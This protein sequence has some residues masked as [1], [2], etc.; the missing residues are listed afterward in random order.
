[1]KKHLADKYPRI[2]QQFDRIDDEGFKKVGREPFDIWLREGFQSLNRSTEE[3]SSRQGT[4]LVLKQA[5][6][7]V[8]S[9]TWGEKQQLT[10]HWVKEIWDGATDQLHE[11][12][13][14]SSRLH[15][16]LTN[17]HDEID[18]RVLQ[19]ADV[20][21]ITTT[22][23]ARRIAT[24][25]RIRSKVVICEEA[26]EVLEAHTV[27]A[28]L[29][30]VEH[31]IQIGDHEQLR[32]QINNYN[33]SLE[34][35]QGTMYQLDRSQF[36]RLSAS[37]PGRPALPITQLYLQRRMRPEISTLIR[38]TIYPD[39][40]DH[41]S[42]KKLPDV[43][44]MRNNV[45]WLDHENLEEGR[46]ADMHQKSHSN[47]W[48]VD[49]THALVRHI[50][51]QGVYNSTDLAVL[52]PYSGQLNRLRRN[53]R[54]DFEI[55]LSDRDQETLSKEGFSLEDDLPEAGQTAENPEPGSK[56]LQR[57][58][59]SELLR[60]ATVDNFQGEEAK[61]II[62]SLVRSNTVKKVGFPRT[63]NRINVLISRA[64]H[65]MYLIGN[66]NTYSNQPMWA[67]IQ[68]MLQATG[69]LGKELALCCPRHTATAIQVSQPEQFQRLSPEGGCQ[70]PCERRLPSCG[71]KC[72]GICHSESMHNVFLCPQPCQRL[73]STCQHSCPKICGE[74]C[75]LCMVKVHGVHLPC[76]HLKDDVPC[77]MTREFQSIRC[78][79]PVLKVVPGCNHAFEVPCF[80]DVTAA[81]FRCPTACNEILE[82]GHLCPGSCGACK[83]TKATDQNV[84]KHASCTK[85]C[86]RRFATCNHC[87]TRPCHQ[88]KECGTCL[89]DCE[90]S[91]LAIKA[92]SR[93][94]RTLRCKS[95][96]VVARDYLRL[97]AGALS[98]LLTFYYEASED[99][100]LSLKPTISKETKYDE[101]PLPILAYDQSPTPHPKHIAKTDII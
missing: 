9:L 82:C 77:H 65:G 28:L 44:G 4:T 54:D 33:L 89:S 8:Y 84:T 3:K 42:T 47:L 90:V 45:F 23:L 22:G 61:I 53:L 37:E 62:V 35:S 11:L 100:S 92:L 69:S 87:C 74:E 70:L 97:S 80:R 60:V 67:Q 79:A 49:M 18:R 72:K 14:E 39:L 51:R 56:V 5:T 68:S 12:I 94:S 25:Q 73:F 66:A 13:E 59:M 83:P 6:Q 26:A 20:I 27:S 76:E 7:N 101:Y 41:D 40:K 31:F 98:V 36:E 43:V 19:T 85:V 21:G 91:A 96:R 81:T 58:R 29:P 46:P 32:P 55:V 57:K 88:G 86:G 99:N 63:R 71:H 17:I 75:G 2:Y 16:E 95:L 15:K 30:S 52:T 38:Q 50:L 1:M 64:Q 10:E 24:L 34:S 78:N 93:L 48:E